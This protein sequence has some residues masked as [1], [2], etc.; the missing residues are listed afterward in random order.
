MP[1]QALQQ[2]LT[3]ASSRCLQTRDPGR[4]FVLG[5]RLNYVLLPGQRT[6]D[7]AA[8]DPL[9]AVKALAQPDY[10]LYWKNKLQRPLKEM[11]AVCVSPT[12]LNSLLQ[13]EPSGVAGSVAPLRQNCA[14]DTVT[15]Q[16]TSLLAG[17]QLPCS[18]FRLFRACL[19]RRSS[20]SGLS[21]PQ[22]SQVPC[23]HTAVL[24]L[25]ACRSQVPP[26]ST[27]VR[28]ASQ[29]AALRCRRGVAGMHTSVHVD[30]STAPAAANCSE[31]NKRKGKRQ[32]GMQ[33]FYKSTL[34]C[35]GCRR[36]MPGSRQPGMPA[37]VEGP[38][39]CL[40]TCLLHAA[41]CLGA[42]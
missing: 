11:F 19:E 22:L 38:G 4:A 12:Q 1:L 9:T 35:L 41:C 30:L 7:D 24:S 21:V 3:H 33:A 18:R 6:Q 37:D 20:V 27:G 10:E 2:Q 15:V 23:V 28:C 40:G 31:V 34:R 32:L 17:G 14:A 16:L 13:G 5:E 36:S 42:A 29:H 8:E 26:C 25:N 39:G